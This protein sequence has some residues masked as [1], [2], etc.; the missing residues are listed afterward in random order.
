MYAVGFISYEAAP[1]FDKA[2][3]VHYSAGFPLLRFGL[4]EAP[5]AMDELPPEFFCEESNPGDGEWQFDNSS[6]RYAE[7]I[8]TIKAHLL[9]GDS[10]QVNYTIRQHRRLI[11]DPR[12]LFANM[13]V[14]AAYAAYIECDDFTICSASP[15][16]F[17]DLD[18]DRL[19][20]RPMKGTAPRG[21]TPE[22]DLRLTEWLCTS[23][24]N[25]AEN[26]MIVDMIRNDIGRVAQPGSVTVEDLFK[27]EAHPT[28]LQMT[29][30]IK[31][32][33][34]C[35]VSEILQALFP[36]A[37]ITGA[38]KINTMR[39]IADLE[40]GPRRLYTGAL[41]VIKPDRK[42]RFSVAIRTA[43]VDNR[44]RQVE[45]GTGGGIV[46]DSLP[47]E[48]F[49][50]CRVKTRVV[51]SA[52]RATS[53]DLFETLFWTGDEFYLLER[54]LT[55]L[56]ESAA[57]FGFASSP[58]KIREYF[59]YLANEL[60]ET[61]CRVR[62]ILSERGEFRYERV[63]LVEESECVWRVGIAKYPVDETL[64]W[65]KHKTTIRGVYEQAH[66]RYSHLDDVLLWNRDGLLTEST[67]A[68]VAVRIDDRLCT[69]PLSCGL[70]PGTFRAEMID[71]GELLEKEIPM[72]DLTVDSEIY[73]L[74]SVRRWIPVQLDVDTDKVP[75]TPH[76][77]E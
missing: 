73:L 14:D 12:I 65:L 6:H 48:E 10:Y 32:T 8:G 24:K 7:K 19:T 52:D 36:C 75:I 9:A 45:Y 77:K 37:S 3:T 2:S 35:S 46:W 16:L 31:A 76:E 70:L 68:N 21:D 38:P 69:P 72:R 44:C 11:E 25:R 34:R 4:F 15:E 23:E 20:S 33:T 58:G 71:A 67:I 55:R 40:D 42:A 57:Y 27:V 54:H 5:D 47:E 28:V 51:D 39:I 63:L 1:A 26:L 49:T 64:V 66:A 18:G 56:E 61:R 30:T 74:N 60:P 50:E 53:F 41:G 62:V 22:E 43:I 17:F 59:Q 29:S 13:A